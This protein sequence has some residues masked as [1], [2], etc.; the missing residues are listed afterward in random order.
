[1]KK[2]IVIIGVIILG[3][4]MF[5]VWTK[6]VDDINTPVEAKYYDAALTYKTLC[7]Q[8]GEENIN[9]FGLNED[10]NGNIYITICTDKVSCTV[11]D[12]YYKVHNQG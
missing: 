4:G 12:K 5:K 6:A 10:E 1:M 7:E 2:I 9:Y 3:V 11:S 8:Y